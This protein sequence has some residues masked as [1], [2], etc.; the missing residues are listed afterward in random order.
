MTT[1]YLTL[2]EGLKIFRDAT[3]PFIVEKLQ[4]AYGD[5]WWERGV[6]RCFKQEDIERLRLLFEKRY[7]SLVVER[8]GDEL[9]EMLD[10]NLF[11]NIIEGNWKQVFHEVIDPLIQEGA[12]V[13]IRVEVAAESEGGIREN[14]VEL[15]IKESLHQRGATPEVEIE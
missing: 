13:A 3:L 14:L 9:A 7:D 8:P 5:D 11:G 15:T 10:I 6:A 1:N 4:A 12:E 2:Y